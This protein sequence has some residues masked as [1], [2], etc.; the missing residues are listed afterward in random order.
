M[1]CRKVRRN[2]FSRADL[3]LAGTSVVSIITDLIFSLIL[4]IL[5]RPVKYIKI[6]SCLGICLVIPFF[7]DAAVLQGRWWGVRL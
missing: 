6:P 7:C 4:T 5:V 1:P 3:V 2:F